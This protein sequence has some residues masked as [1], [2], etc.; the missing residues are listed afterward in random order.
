[1]A[2]GPAAC[3]TGEGL[4][5]LL[6]RQAPATP[7]IVSTVVS[8]EDMAPRIGCTH[9]ARLLGDQNASLTEVLRRSANCPPEGTPGWIVVRGEPA[10]RNYEDI[11]RGVRGPPRPAG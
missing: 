6:T 1:M 11:G 2:L 3:G 7:P 8:T 10:F 9:I 4:R 5:G